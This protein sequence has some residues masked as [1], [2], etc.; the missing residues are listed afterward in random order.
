MTDRDDIRRLSTGYA[1]AVDAL[2]GDAFAALFTADGELWVPDV[3]RSLVPTIRRAG[4]EELRRIPDG[5]ARY[6][7]TCH[8]VGATSFDVDVDGST[9]TGTV[10][11]VAHHLTAS[12]SGVAAAT[13]GDGGPG[14]DTIWYLRYEDE[15]RRDP[16]GWRIA[17]RELHL[18][19]VEERSVDHTGPGR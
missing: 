16:D 4:F 13:G 6:H 10:M 8:Q 7:A 15:Y 2:D 19:S 18:R 12:A 3:R 14:V 1:A 11:G 17:K 9:A 5:L